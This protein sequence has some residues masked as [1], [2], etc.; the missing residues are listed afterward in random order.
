MVYSLLYWLLAISMVL[1]I[2]CF[3]CG[4]YYYRSSQLIHWPRIIR[5]NII[6]C[7]Q[8]L[9]TKL[10]LKLSELQESR[11]LFA[12]AVLLCCLI[13]KDFQ[14]AVCLALSAF[15]VYEVFIILVF[16]IIRNA[17]K[18]EILCIIFLCSLFNLKCYVGL[19]DCMLVLFYFFRFTKWQLDW[20]ICVRNVY[21]LNYILTI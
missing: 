14:F 2:T 3:Q 11:L 21:S 4:R 5:T 18:Y 7:L 16:I 12:Y 17:F 20:N 9:K 10:S 15:F 19:Y 6:S 13:S 1:V 8:K